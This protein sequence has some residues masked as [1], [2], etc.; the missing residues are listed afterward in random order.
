MDSFD[1]GTLLML[2]VLSLVCIA[3]WTV[4]LP[5]ESVE[6]LVIEV[7]ESR[8]LY[9]CTT[10]KFATFSESTT[11]ITLEGFHEIKVGHIYKITYQNQGY[12]LYNV[13]IEMED[14]GASSLYAGER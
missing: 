12:C 4:T 5:I 10:V 14:M 1:K 8:L 2:G 7:D 9:P 3:I 11:S 13:L 6:G